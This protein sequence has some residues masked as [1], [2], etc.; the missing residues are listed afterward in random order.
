[1]KKE[2]TYAEQQKRKEK[3]KM[4]IYGIFYISVCLVPFIFIFLPKDS[5]DNSYDKS[6]ACYVAKQEVENKLKSPSSAVF[7]ECSY[8]SIYPVGEIWYVT[9]SVE[10]QNSFGAMIK[11]KFEVRIKIT[12]KNK[13]LVTYVRVD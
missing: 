13:Y 11:T 8:M 4:I 1:M 12:G 3:R 10:A 2:L 5:D 9:G 6:L 7:P